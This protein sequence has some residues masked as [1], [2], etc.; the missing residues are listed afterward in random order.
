[1]TENKT[2]QDDNTDLA[3]FD[4]VA[5]GPGDAPTDDKP[6]DPPAED[7][8]VPAEEVAPEPP[9]ETPAEPQD[10]KQPHIPKARFDEAIAKER[11]RA[12]ARAAELQAQID[13]LKAGPPVDYSEEIKALDAAW[14]DDR[15]DGS[16][17]EYLTK[18]TQ[19]T[20]AEA[21]QEAREELE[22]EQA[23][24]A[25][26]KAAQ[27]WNDASA[28][29]A[30]AH[31]IY[32]KSHADFD[33]EEHAALEAALHGVFAKYPN[34]SNADKLEKAHK[35]VE[36]IAVAEG[37]REPVAP[38]NPHAARN[39][40]DA[41]AQ[42]SASAAPNPAAAGSGDRGRTTFPGIGEGM[43]PEDYKSLPKELRESKELASF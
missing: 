23:E 32:D 29:F 10:S 33:A 3:D 37:R 18:R 41:K 13:A 27:D 12:D 43:K 40:Q 34:A 36:A 7:A 8:E 30:K 15:F 38:P 31:P 42:A 11:E 26:A 35:I 17:D 19:L 20:K 5:A 6:A 25:A 2:P 16:H 28:D 21:K 24:K 1:M 4:D 22:R 14:N 9:A 39:A